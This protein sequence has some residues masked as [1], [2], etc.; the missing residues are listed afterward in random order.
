MTK[1]RQAIEDGV[2][3]FSLVSWAILCVVAALMGFIFYDGLEWMVAIW[4]RKEEYS[5]GFMIPAI[6][7]FLIWQKKDRLERVAFSGSWTGFA[8]V[9]VGIAIFMLGELSTLYIIIQYSFIV[10]L[11]G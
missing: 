4:N 7:L 6:A 1:E 11:F 2:W 3:G 5:H 8:V 9:L 10:A